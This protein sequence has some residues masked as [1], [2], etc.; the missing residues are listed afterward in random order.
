MISE[1]VRVTLTSLGS[2][3]A[4]FILTKLMGEKQISQMNMFDYVTGIT[5][6]SIAAEMATEI[7]RSP[8]NAVLAMS[9]Y[10]VL[11][12]AVSVITQRSLKLR[13][14]LS[15]KIV[16]LMEN[17]RL[18]RKGFKTAHLDL[19][20]FLMLARIQGYFDPSQI[21]TALME[22][23]GTVSFLPVE[24]DRPA[25]VGDL[26]LKMPQSRMA[27]NII[28]DGKIMEENLRRSGISL[29]RLE[30]EYKK[31]GFSNPDEIFLATVNEGKISFYQ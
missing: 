28:M 27:Y 19:S 20:D 14:K 7:D 6:G 2:A 4:L 13:R 16:V 25:T 9:I 12:I 31:A 10:A 8:L 24:D 5:I 26:S 15:G 1:L 21:S 17:G 30:S 22:P 18:N 23:N 29:R 11:A 3:V